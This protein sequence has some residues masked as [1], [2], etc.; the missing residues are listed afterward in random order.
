MTTKQTL[1]LSFRTNST[2]QK[3]FENYMF[4]QLESKNFESASKH[5]RNGMTHYTISG[6]WSNLTETRETWDD[7]VNY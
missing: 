6:T 7:F 1:V 4:G 2:P 3:N 5:H